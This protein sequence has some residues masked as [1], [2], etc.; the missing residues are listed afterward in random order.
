M[1]F[2]WAFLFSTANDFSQSSEGL[3]HGVLIWKDLCDVGV[4][5]NDISLPH[6]IPR[7]LA[8]DPES[9]ERSGVHL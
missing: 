3:I 2:Y 7:P 6:L 1:L 4:R 8:E 9:F 5:D